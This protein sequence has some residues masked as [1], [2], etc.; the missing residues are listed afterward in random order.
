M[1]ARWLIPLTVVIA[2]AFS[3]AQLDK[4]VI[5][6][7]TPEDQAL[8]AITSEQDNSKKVTMYED[9]LTKF[10]GN[11]QA[12]AYG[13]WQVSQA[14]QNSGDMQ[15]ALEYGD[16]ALAKAPTNLDILV[17]QANIAQQ[18][19]D[20]AKVLNYAVKAITPSIS[21]QSQRESMTPNGHHESATLVNRA[22]I[23]TN[24]LRPGLSTLS[25]TRKMR[26]L[27]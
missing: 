5:P 20:P 26:R 4:I 9:F 3:F 6:A 27:G 12:V 15:K 1:R 10:A 7:G 8:T 22:R 18:L 17:S 19:K 16:K 11:S 24:F 14:Y 25:L 13:N 21:S 2:S 23:R